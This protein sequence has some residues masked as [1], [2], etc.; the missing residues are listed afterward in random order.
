[1]A[2]PTAA[3]PP[4]TQSRRAAARNDTPNDG[5]DTMCE[6]IDFLEP[7]KKGAWPHPLTNYNSCYNSCREAA[8]V[9]PAVAGGSELSRQDLRAELTTLNH[10]GL[11]DVGG[12]LV[13]GLFALAVRSRRVVSAIRGSV[14][15]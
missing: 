6:I 14:G 3:D 8:V 11:G 12:A 4:S 9:F 2:A 15:D 5:A 7:C 10:Y 1:M 13:D